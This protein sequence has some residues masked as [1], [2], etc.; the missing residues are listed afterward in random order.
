MPHCTKCGAALADNAAFCTA[1]GSPQ[2]ATPAGAAP[3]PSGALPLGAGAQ[4]GLAEN[5]AGLLSYLAGWITGLIFLL[6]DKRQSVQFHARQS[7]TIF[8]GLTLIHLLII[9]AFGFGLV[10]GWGIFALV[11]WLINI[12]GFVLWILC[13]VKAY[14]GERYRVPIAADL[15]EKIFGKA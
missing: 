5:V 10:L 2:A 12:L 11:S 4:S 7:I 15:S 14:Q 3:P 6:I 8:G 1:C 9:P 13:M